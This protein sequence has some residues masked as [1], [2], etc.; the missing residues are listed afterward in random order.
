MLWRIFGPK[1][2]ERVGGLKRL[3]N[4]DIHNLYTLTNVIRLVKED[5]MGGTVAWM[6]EMTKA[7]SILAGKPEGRRALGSSRCK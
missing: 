1:R 4:E 5:G 2:E 3:Q 7:Y 6:K